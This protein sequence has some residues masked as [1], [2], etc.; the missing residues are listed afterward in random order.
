MNPLGSS[1][2]PTG[3]EWER[4]E[5]L[6]SVKKRCEEKM[7]GT[8][9]KVRGLFR[10]SSRTDGDFQSQALD[11]SLGPVGVAKRCASIDAAA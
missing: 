6:L 7:S 4:C 8:V 2:R 10:P 5:A 1:T 3:A 11:N 9:Y